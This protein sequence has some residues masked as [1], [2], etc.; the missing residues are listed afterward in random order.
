M[1]NRRVAPCQA[2][3][4]SKDNPGIKVEIPTCQ[5]SDKFDWI[6]VEQST[7]VNSLA[8]SLIKV[9]LISLSLALLANAQLR[10]NVEIHA[11]KNPGHD[12]ENRKDDPASSAN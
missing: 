8:R 2:Q 3:T 11:L 5:R 10:P 4:S 7:S 9:C 6:P 1:I 12:V